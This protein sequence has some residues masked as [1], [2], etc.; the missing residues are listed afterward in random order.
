MAKDL[1]T[2]RPVKP[3]IVV[4]PATHSR[5]DESREIFQTLVVSGGSHP[6]FADGLPDLLGSFRTDRRQKAHEEL[7]IAILCPSRLEGVAQ[8]VE[9]HMLVLPAPI[10]ILAKTIRVFVG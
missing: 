8:E 3:T 1:N 9:R 2:L 7:P 6:P 4:H 10:G 5:I